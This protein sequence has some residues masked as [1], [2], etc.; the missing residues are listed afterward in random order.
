MNPTM[1]MEHMRTEWTKRAQGGLLPHYPQGTSLYYIQGHPED[2]TI[3]YGLYEM[4][5]LGTTQIVWGA[6]IVFGPILEKGATGPAT[7]D[8]IAQ[9]R[10]IKLPI[11]KHLEAYITLT[12]GPCVHSKDFKTVC[13]V[14]NASNPEYSVRVGDDFE[15]AIQTLFE[16]AILNQ[17]IHVPHRLN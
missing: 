11:V 14:A 16:L 2:R 1:F 6:E 10:A 5:R 7:I 4:R 12:P 15:T 9:L 3:Q 13:E 17:H 8:T